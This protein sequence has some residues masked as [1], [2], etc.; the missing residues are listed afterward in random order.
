MNIKKYNKVKEELESKIDVY[1]EKVEERW[2]KLIGSGCERID[3]WYVSENEG[4]VFVTSPH[5]LG[6]QKVDRIP[7]KFFEIKDD[8]EAVKEFQ[9]FNKQKQRE[10]QLKEIQE[11]RESR[12]EEYKRLKKEFEPNEVILPKDSS[13]S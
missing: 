9:E 12:W 4:I 11:K 13:T 2:M 6:G 7:I 3:R 10:V 1:T 8:V 5:Q